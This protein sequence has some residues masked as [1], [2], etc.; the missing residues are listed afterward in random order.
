MIEEGSLQGNVAVIPAGEAK[1]K[2]K[3]ETDQQIS[4]EPKICRLSGNIFPGSDSFVG[5]RGWQDGAH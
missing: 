1:N 2:R 5:L 4:V 3:K